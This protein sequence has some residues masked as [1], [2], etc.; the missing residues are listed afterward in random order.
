M[1]AKFASCRAR[2]QARWDGRWIRESA[3]RAGLPPRISVPVFS[4]TL[5]GR[6]QRR[7][8]FGDAP[9][10]LQQIERLDKLVAREGMLSAKA[11]WI[12]T[13]LNFV[14]LEGG[15]SDAA[16]GNHFALMNA[17]TDAGDANH[18][19]ILAKLHAGFRE[20]DALDAAHFGIR[21]EQQSELGFQWNFE[22]DPCE[23]DF[24]SCLCRRFFR[25]HLHVIRVLQARRPWR[26]RRPRRRRRKH[27]H[28]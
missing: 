23:T 21:G 16:A 25:H 1:P 5:R 12:R 22:M 8:F 13:L 3:G 10:V 11:V 19:S 14:A 26:W 2:D 17:R 28:E 24:A 15:G 4:G 9:R 20:R 27:P 7:G 6:M 18:E